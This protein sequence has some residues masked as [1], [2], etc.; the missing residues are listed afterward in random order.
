ML[1]TG[2]T[3]LVLNA[4]IVGCGFRGGLGVDSGMWVVWW[5]LGGGF[6]ELLQFVGKL[7]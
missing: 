1:S 7:D 2:I 4:G 5:E 3:G 6:G